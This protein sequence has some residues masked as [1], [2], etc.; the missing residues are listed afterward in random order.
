MYLPRYAVCGMCTPPESNATRPSR[1]P[2]QVAADEREAAEAKFREVAEAYE[3]LS[4]EEKRARFDS[5]QDVEEQGGGGGGHGHG[6]P[7]QHGG[8]HY[9]FRF[10]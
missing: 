10:G 5:G 1:R 3:V 2:L 4:D 7:F 6:H 9:E 8:M